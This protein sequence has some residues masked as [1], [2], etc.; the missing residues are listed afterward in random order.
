MFSTVAKGVLIADTLSQRL[1]CGDALFTRAEGFMVRSLRGRLIVL[2]VLLVAAA[3][4]AG[5][6]MMG[7]FRQ[8]ATARAGQAEAE[9]GRACDAITGAYRFYSAGWQGPA[10][11]SNDKALRRDLIAIVATALH[12]RPGIEGGIWRGG[13]GSLAYAFPTYRGAGPKT[14]V[15]EAEPARIEAANRA[16]LAGDRQAD[17]PRRSCF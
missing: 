14:D 6:L 16:A 15:P 3:V 8:S 12:D 1:I 13:A 11:G 9:I 2:L 17:N 4:A 5:A 10:A 7:L